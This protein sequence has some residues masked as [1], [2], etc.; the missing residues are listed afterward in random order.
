MVNYPG[1]PI[2][3]KLHGYQIEETG[4]Y[5]MGYSRDPPV[6]INIVGVVKQKFQNMVSVYIMY[7]RWCHFSHTWGFMGNSPTP[8]FEDLDYHR[9]QKFIFKPSIACKLN[10]TKH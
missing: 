7:Y 6:I 3:P 9:V 4:I 2:G 1:M 8:I 10:D 5:I